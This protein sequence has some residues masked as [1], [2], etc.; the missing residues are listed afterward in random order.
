[1]TSTAEGEFNL[2]FTTPSSLFLCIA[3]W[4]G[5][6]SFSLTLVL[7]AQIVVLR[8]ML[9]RCRRRE[10]KTINKWRPI[11]NQTISD[12]TPAILPVMRRRDGIVFFNL[13]VHLHASLR[14]SATEALNDLGYRL[15]CDA[16]ARKLLDDGNRAER[17]LA[18]LVLGYLQDRQAW[19]GLLLKARQPDSTT[20]FYA[21]CALVQVDAVAALIQLTPDFIRREDWPV[22]QVV[23]LLKGVRDLYEPHLINSLATLSAPHMLRALRIAEGLHIDLP[24]AMHA[25]ML[26]NPSPDLIVAALRVVANAALLNTIRGLASHGDW[27]VRVHVGK[28]LGRIGD[29]SDTDVLMRL[30]MDEQW[31]VRYRAAQ[32]LVGMSSFDRHEIDA[33]L[34]NADDPFAGE[35]LAQVLA[36]SAAQ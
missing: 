30:L 18:M 7:G 15:Q 5:V 33:L 32:A 24:P 2:G 13:W 36:E 19:S 29:G 6:G 17:L 11:L 9:G 10:T 26:R 16:L 34:R 8:L 22:S 14:G 20:S 23:T 3:F 35:M 12:G 4:I 1:M 25:G 21:A 27:R 28:A 31:W